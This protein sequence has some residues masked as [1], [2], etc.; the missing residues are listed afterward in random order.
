MRKILYFLP[1]V[2]GCILYIFLGI[3]SSFDSIHFLA[4]I[5]LVILFIAALLM[6]NNKWWGCILGIA[7]GILLIYM[8]T[9]ETGQ[10]IK[11]TPFGIIMCIYYIVC[12]IL[13]YKK[14]NTKE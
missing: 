13:S 9:Q 2:L 10:I 4:W 3:A 6:K 7:V 5:A 8:G 11:E 12:A 1:F 14:S